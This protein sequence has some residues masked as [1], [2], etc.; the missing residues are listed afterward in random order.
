MFFCRPKK[1]VRKK[2]DAE[3]K[4][5]GEIGTQNRDVLRSFYS[6]L[7]LVALSLGGKS[8]EECFQTLMF[9]PYK[10]PQVVSETCVRHYGGWPKRAFSSIP[11]PCIGAGFSPSSIHEMTIFEGMEHVLSWEFLFLAV[12]LQNFRLSVEFRLTKPRKNR[13]NCHK[14]SL[15]PPYRQSLLNW[16]VPKKKNYPLKKAVRGYDCLEPGKLYAYMVAYQLDDWKSWDKKICVSP[17]SKQWKKDPSVLL[18]RSRMSL[19]MMS[20][21]PKSNGKTNGWFTWSQ[22]PRNRRNIYGWI[23]LVLVIF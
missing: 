1:V 8:E 10:G 11:V 12:L 14:K 17:W 15:K 13:W 16:R 20:A 21:N 6:L 4:R 18:S 5:K 22:L 2:R 7:D 9:F 3:N 23:R 19:N